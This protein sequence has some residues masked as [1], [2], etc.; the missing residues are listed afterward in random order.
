MKSAT[1]IQGAASLDQLRGWLASSD[2]NL[3]RSMLEAEIKYR[4]H[5]AKP[6]REQ[7]K[8]NEREATRRRIER[9]W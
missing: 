7:Q 1:E 8:I 9:T 5:R 6:V 3:E 2:S 4:E